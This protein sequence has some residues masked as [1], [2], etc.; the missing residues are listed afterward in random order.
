MIWIE[1]R[2]DRQSLPNCYSAKNI[3]PTMLA[4]S[5]SLSDVALAR[6]ILF[7]E[8]KREGW[9]VNRRAGVVCPKCR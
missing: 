6:R 3:G 1:V 9:A 2:C 8:A 7:D 5:N 4:P